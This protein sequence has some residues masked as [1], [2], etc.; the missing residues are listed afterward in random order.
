MEL[1]EVIDQ[2]PEDAGPIGLLSSDEF[3]LG[4]R[5]FDRAL[6]A[7]ARGPRVAIMP[8]ADHEHADMIMNNA[9]AHLTP[10]GATV[11]EADIG[12]RPASGT[13]RDADVYYLPG[14]DPSELLA[15][16]RGTL[17]PRQLIDR[18]MNG[19]ALAG[20]SAGAMALCKA[21]LIPEPGADK[22]TVWT[23]G[24]GPIEKVGLAVH[25]T[26]RPHAWLRRVAETSRVPVLAM[27]DG[28]GVLLRNGRAPE[29]IG[30]GRVSFA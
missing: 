2:I 5:T 19:A 30:R 16:L 11:F 3:T 26:T 21:C 4:A 22:P 10:L 17:L 14:G 6:L 18:W 20:S 27:D 7:A 28:T 1:A 12:H 9:R 15:C 25:V 23:D 13:L 24:L 29:V 8:C